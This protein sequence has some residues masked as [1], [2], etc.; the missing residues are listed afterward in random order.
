MVSRHLPPHLPLCVHL[1][2]KARRVLE[3]GIGHKLKHVA[4]GVEPSPA[5]VIHFT[6]TTQTEAARVWPLRLYG[7]WHG[8]AVRE[9]EVAATRAVLDP[10]SESPPSG[11][12]A[13]DADAQRASTQSAQLAR[14]TSSP[15]SAGAAAGASDGARLGPRMIALV[16]GLP[17]TPLPP[18]PWAS[19]NAMHGVVGALASLSG[20]ALVMPSLNC[21]GAQ[22]R[23]QTGG[24][25]GKERLS[26]RCFWH[27]QTA[28]G[29]RCVLRIGFCTEPPLATPDEAE[30]AISRARADGATGRPV[31]RLDLSQPVASSQVEAILAAAASEERIVLVSLTLPP[32]RK[33]SLGG[34]R[35]PSRREL[36]SQQV[37]DEVA[38]NADPHAELAKHL[39]SFRRQCSDLTARTKLADKECNNICS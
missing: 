35:K 38:L 20:R 30:R 7:Y 31:Y 5:V 23:G 36:L 19:L 2:Q 27:L 10:S 1:M 28:H 17:S 6:C 39:R 24:A 37:L 22:V 21:T 12:L 4:Y 3:Q 15:A 11:E 16:D 33:G 13:A 32:A 29:V 34:R 26:G 18:M 25:I 9:A 14:A 8:A